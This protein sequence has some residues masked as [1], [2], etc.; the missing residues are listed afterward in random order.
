MIIFGGLFSK[1]MSHL[2][3]KMDR[4]DRS[5]FDRPLFEAEIYIIF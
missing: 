3:R 4:K 5:E 2:V 1:M